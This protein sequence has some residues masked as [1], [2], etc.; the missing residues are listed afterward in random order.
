MEAFT[1]LAG[2]QGEKT[3]ALHN[4][5]LGSVQRI[6]PDF[7]WR[8]FTGRSADRLID[9][10]EPPRSVDSV[11]FPNMDHSATRPIIEG[12]LERKSRNKLSWGYST[13][14]YVVT[15]S[16]FLHEFKDSDNIRTDPKP[17]LSIYLPD[18]VVGTPDGEK[19]HVKGKDKSKGIGSK[20]VGSAELNFKAHT[21]ADA[22]KWYQA[23]SS[24]VG[25]GNV[26]AP[27]ISS[28]PTSPIQTPS[29]STE[30]KKI[31]G[32]HTQQTQPNP[33]IV[34]VSEHQAQD[35]GV[36]GHAP[37]PAVAP[38]PEKTG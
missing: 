33:P 36:T 25:S 10:N 27:A 4:D 6:T 2:G 21:A 1:Q 29:P 35:S 37:P 11:Q 13:G 26:V 30:D 23:I 7:E 18:S 34:P 5:M 15:P 20:L 9:P 19:F 14:Y 3:R 31:L 32:E 12:S 38:A 22:Q 24:I 16:K 8:N 28:T 17:E